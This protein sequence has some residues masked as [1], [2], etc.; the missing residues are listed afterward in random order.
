MFREKNSRKEKWYW[1]TI[2]DLPSAVA[3]SNKGVWAA[4][5]VAVFT[6]L[7]TVLRPI[8]LGHDTEIGAWPFLDAAIFGGLALGI[9]RRSRICAVTGLALFIVETILKSAVTGLGA[10]GSGIAGFFIVLFLIA[11]K[12]NFAFHSLKSKAIEEHE[13]LL[14]EETADEIR[15]SLRGKQFSDSVD[16]LR[17]DRSR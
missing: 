14:D 16:L 7:T 1:P 9:Y 10:I 12:G 3:A 8:L 6:I 2:V 11:V 4:G 17:E 5:L 13:Q 15:N